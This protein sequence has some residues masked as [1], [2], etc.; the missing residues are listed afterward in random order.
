MNDNCTIC[1]EPLSE[2]EATYALNCNH[3][4]HRDCITRWLHQHPTCPLCREPVD[5]DHRYVDDGIISEERRRYIETLKSVCLF[6]AQ[7]L[8]WLFPVGLRG[9]AEKAVELLESDEG[10]E[11]LRVAGEDPERALPRGLV[12]LLGASGW[13][14]FVAN[15]G[16][17]SL[18]QYLSTSEGSETTT[19]KLIPTALD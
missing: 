17:S 13:A 5:A 6:T 16:L 3:T 11:L 19:T 9:Y 18:L 10:K 14:Q 8:E 7:G 12:T 1:L 15:G 2:D 4:Y